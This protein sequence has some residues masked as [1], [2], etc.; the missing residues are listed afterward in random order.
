MLGLAPSMLLSGP[1]PLAD[2]RG[3]ARSLSPSIEGAAGI[4][5]WLPRLHA[6]EKGAR[7]GIIL[8]HSP[9]RP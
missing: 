4:G 3:I 6:F 5:L 9:F 1:E 7:P 8:P 2:P